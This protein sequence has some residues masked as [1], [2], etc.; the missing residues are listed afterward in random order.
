MV[1]SLLV[2]GIGSG[3]HC[4]YLSFK[5]KHARQHQRS[6]ARSRDIYNLCPRHDSHNARVE[7]VLTPRAGIMAANRLHSIR[8][9]LCMTPIHCKCDTAYALG[10]LV[11]VESQRRDGH[12]ATKRGFERVAKKI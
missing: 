4:R 5:V 8:I 6:R 11:H 7:C 9:F 3:F 1:F 10:G 12:N 2:F